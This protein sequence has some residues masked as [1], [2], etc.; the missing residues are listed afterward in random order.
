M[1]RGVLGDKTKGGF[2]K[3]EGKTRLALDAVSGDYK[4][5]AEFRLPR[6]DYIDAVAHLHAQGRYQE[7]MQV[8][9]AAE[10]DEAALAR[11]VIA[12]YVSYAFHRVGEVTE[13]ID[14][15]DRI[16]AMG[17]NWAPPSVLVDVMGG[18][19]AAVE[20][21]AKA[22]VRVPALLEQAART[23][24]PERFFGNRQINVGRFFVAG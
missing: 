12:G 14:G 19:A 17:F 6:L 18:A 2:F 10:G 1:A 21:I 5:V 13:T 11:K 20:M 15:I 8:F 22:G 16:M 9:L 24:K 23:G 3:K 4:P 7:G